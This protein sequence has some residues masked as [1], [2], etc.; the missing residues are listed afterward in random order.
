MLQ[1]S[2]HW[3]DGQCGARSLIDPIVGLVSRLRGELKPLLNLFSGT[4]V[5]ERTYGVVS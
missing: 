2:A 4:A 5:P 1:C 3:S